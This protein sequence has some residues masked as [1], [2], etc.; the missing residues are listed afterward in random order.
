MT[1][2][3]TD[4]SPQLATLT[5][6]TFDNDEWIFET[7]YD[8]YRAF[9]QIENGSC[10]LVSRNA[11]S[12]DKKF[13]ELL[14]PLRNL[15]N[16]I[17]LDGEIVVQ[18]SKGRDKFQWLQNH[19]KD[20]SKGEL[21]YFVFD[22]LYFNGYDLRNLPLV[23]RKKILKG[24]LPKSKNILYSEHIEKDG[25]RFFAKAEQN[26]L[27][28]IIAKKAT[29]KYNEGKR[30]KDWLKIKTTL[31]QEMV[32]GGYTSPQGSRTGIGALICGYYEGEKLLYSG[33]V[34]TGFDE[35]TL[36][37]LEKKLKKLERNTPPFDQ[38]PKLKDAHWVTPSLVAQIKFMEWTD[39]GNMR[40]P[41]FLGLK[42]DK[43]A[44]K[45]TLESK[46]ATKE[47]PKIISTKDATLVNS[48]VAFTNLEKPFW[49]KLNLTKGDVVRYYD[50]ISDLIL[51]FMIDRPQSLRRNP[52]GIKNE[53]F[54]Q[55]NVAGLTPD[56]ISTRKIKSKS[57][58]ES[59]EYLLCQDRDTLLFLA[60][61]GSIEMNPWSSRVGSINSP[62]YMV[63]DLDPLDASIKDLVT[64]ALKVKEFLDKMELKS[65]IKTSGGKGL[66]IY[67]P[68]KND[69]TYKQTQNIC[70]ILSQMVH[71]DLPEITSLERSPSKRK[72]KIYL[73]YLQNAKGKTMASV[74]SVRPRE[75]AG[76]S[77]PLKWSEVNFAL[78]L[79]SFNLKT[80]DARLKKEGDL[81]SGFFENKNDLAVALKKL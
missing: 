14:E 18:D 80:I 7:K 68:I 42:T 58:E 4:W 44:Q 62:D 17:L 56:W 81:W 79:G 71:R 66:H 13:Q 63:F 28:G 25:I 32:I 20:P 38:E 8:G 57:T 70:H 67:I 54:F 74:Y 34:G 78:D 76:V 16:N 50:R 5:D 26:Q 46:V 29:S 52:D 37:E 23:T 55:K 36:K 41:V 72:G 65:F 12:F 53:G 9:A 21:K 60:N 61:W 35:I 39:D 51:P 31:Q 59:I 2:F 40:H 3:P 10:H 33:K 6:K 77:T 45:V 75:N 49:P 19:D 47:D 11:N 24:I 73:D 48:K 69:Y 15:K 1:S 43:N 30:S 27:E 22:I 64:T